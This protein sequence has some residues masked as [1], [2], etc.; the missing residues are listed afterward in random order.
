MI[1]KEIAVLSKKDNKYP[2]N[3]KIFK[4]GFNIKFNNKVTIIS[5]ENG[6]GKSTILKYIADNIGFNILGG[7]RNSNYQ[8]TENLR[9]LQDIKLSWSYKT[10]K[11]FY[12]RSDT[13]NSYYNYIESDPAILAYYQK[14]FSELSHGE[15]FLELFD[16]F[17]EG[18][19]L[20][21]EP[22]NALSPQNQLRLLKIIHDLSQQEDTQI[23]IVTHSPIIMSYPNADFIYIDDEIKRMDYKDTQHYVIYKM[24]LDCPE[25][26]FN[27]LF[28]EDE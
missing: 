12:F 1:L 15:S 19:F 28:A 16:S 4:E 9:E 22:E 11:G 13:F 7:N 18:I 10:K 20:L 3:I 24:M 14:K 27:I 8:A 26:L 5:G 23:I 17:R 21:D 6:C 2:Y 25:K